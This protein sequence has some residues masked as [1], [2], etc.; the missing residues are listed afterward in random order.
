MNRRSRVLWVVDLAQMLGLGTLDTNIQQYNLVIVQVGAIALG[1]AVQQVDGL[2]WIDPNQIQ[3]P[4]GQILPTLLP[5][6]RGCAL[7]TQDQKQ[8]I[9]LVLD[10]EAIAQSSLLRSV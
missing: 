7:Q 5:Y 4:I 2:N 10:A 9:L 1:L 6:L 8:N 3:A